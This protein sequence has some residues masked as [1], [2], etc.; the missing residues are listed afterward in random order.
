MIDDAE[1]AHV[2]AAIS[3]TECALTCLR[4][5][6]LE[7]DPAVTPSYLRSAWFDLR[8]ATKSTEA[9]APQIPTSVWPTP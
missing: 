4:L 5:V 2:T 7:N 9:A 8:A 6:L 3:S 1:R